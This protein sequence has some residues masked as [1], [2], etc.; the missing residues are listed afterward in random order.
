MDSN[1][2]EKARANFVR[3]A[4]EF[5]FTFISPYIIDEKEGISAFGF[6]AGYGSYY[7]AVIELI[8]P[9]LFETNKELA[10]I[11]VKKHMWYSF[12]NVEL[13]TGK[14]DRDYFQELLD[15]W[16][17]FSH[18]DSNDKYVSLHDCK[19]EMAWFE[20]G[21]L[22]F[23]FP[24]GFWITPDNPESD[25]DVLVRTDASK[26]EFVLLDGDEFDIQIFVVEENIFKQS[27]RKEWSVHKLVSAINSGEV[28]LEFLYQYIDGCSRIVECVLWSKRKPYCRECQIKLHLRD[29]HYHW[30]KILKDRIW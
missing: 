14:Y 15:D 21:I 8:E 4:E 1:M 6:I 24:D 22:G 3:A 11:C 16:K 20:N 10:E 2:I 19:A 29:V 27:V 5:G 18:C 17:I 30:N 9:P 25:L 23:E 13:L 26:I 7:G 28:T 12:L